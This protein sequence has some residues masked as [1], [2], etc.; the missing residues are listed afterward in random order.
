MKVSQSEFGVYNNAP[1]S[2]FTL[3]N[4][5][6]M[7]VKVSNYGATI[8][9]ITVPTATGERE[10][11]VCGFD[12]FENYFSNEYIENAPYFGCT[13]GRYSSQI[14][15]AVFVLDRNVYELAK[16]CGENN[17]HGG[18]DGFDKKMWKA[19]VV[20]ADDEV[21]IK[22]SLESPAFEEGFPGNVVVFVFISLLKDNVVRV[23]YSADTDADTPLS[24]TNHTYFN[25]SGFKSDIQNHT[26]SIKA[27]HKLFM[28]D[29]G[30]AT[31]D[32]ENLDNRV[33]DLRKP[34]EIGEVQQTMSDGFEHYYI[35]DKKDGL[36]EKVAHFNCE[37]SNRSLEIYTSEPG[38]LFYTGKYTSDALSR[39]SGEQFGKYRAF[40]CETHRYPNGPNIEKSPRSITKSSEQYESE[41]IFKFSF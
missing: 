37:E 9:S 33:D 18:K 2:L 14:K 10:Q 25:L 35:F 4:G 11:L 24:L 26:V 34:K 5:N 21:T 3:T 27:S 23:R 19:E 7:E 13:V 8:T 15:N 28:D 12:T 20:T 22:L 17:L 6:G 32:I 40:C 16:N 38:M 31:G 39:E 41:T 1:V 29:T 36:I 30:A